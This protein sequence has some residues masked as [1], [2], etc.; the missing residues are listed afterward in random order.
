MQPGGR[1]IPGEGISHL[2]SSSHDT[3]YLCAS[4]FKPWDGGCV[5]LMGIMRAYDDFLHLLCSPGFFK[6]LSVR[7]C[8]TGSL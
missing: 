6:T 3:M 7:Y 2:M 5:V 8:L 1:D 4:L